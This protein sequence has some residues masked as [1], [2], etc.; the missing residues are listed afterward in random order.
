MASKATSQP[1]LTVQCTIICIYNNNNNNNNKY[2]ITVLVCVLGKRM[3]PKTLTKASYCLHSWVLQGLTI[4]EQ[5]VGNRQK[6]TEILS[7]H[8]SKKLAR[9]KNDQ[10]SELTCIKKHS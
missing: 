6:M 4:Y 2:M 3:E 10:T 7:L 9:L 8:L 1:M 5:Q